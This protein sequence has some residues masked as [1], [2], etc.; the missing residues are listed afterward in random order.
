MISYYFSTFLA[1]GQFFRLNDH[2]TRFCPED[3]PINMKECNAAEQ[4]ATII[5][6]YVDGGRGGEINIWGSLFYSCTCK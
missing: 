5:D 6:R 4:S 2:G 1:G 3:L